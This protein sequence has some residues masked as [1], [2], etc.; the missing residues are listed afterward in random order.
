[1]SIVFSFAFHFWYYSFIFSY[2]ILVL[3][4]ILYYRLHCIL[5]LSGLCFALFLTGYIAGEFEATW[6]TMISLELQDL[7]YCL[8]F[9][10]GDCI[11]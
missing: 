2:R 9:I 11:L 4:C 10:F 5:F 1:M 8:D 3:P 7:V 6:S